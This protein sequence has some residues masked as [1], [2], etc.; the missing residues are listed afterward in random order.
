MKTVRS[1]LLLCLAAMAQEE[2]RRQIWNTE[3]LKQRPPAKKAAPARRPAPAT[4]GF[5]LGVTVW[6]L[7]QVVASEPA[8]GTRLLVLE[9]GKRDEMVP[10]RIESGTALKPGDRVRVTVEAPRA[11]YLYVVDRE[12]YASGKVGEPYLI[13]P[14]WQ[15]KRGD[16][17]MAAGR[18]IEIPDQHD[19]PNCFTIRPSRP[20]QIGELLTMLVTTEPL[21]GLAIGR[22]PLRLRDEQYAE[23]EKKY[24]VPAQHFEL[25]GG[26]GKPW[27]P[28]EKRAG[29]DHGSRLTQADPLP[30]TFYRV[31]DKAG[32][33]ILLNLPLKI[34]Q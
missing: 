12:Q 33:P 29:A 16:N 19:E 34:K 6:R 26:A 11:G 9:G 28:Q 31:P 20:D 23:W 21:A 27:T 4:A 30:Q 5:L 10:E 24:G 18:L 1:C 13:Y 8:G 14:N 15:T 32:P 7:R 22:E 3:F 17:T 2:N 25:E